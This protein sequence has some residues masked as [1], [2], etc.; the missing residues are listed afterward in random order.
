MGIFKRISDIITAN[1][2]DLTEGFENPEQ[3]LRQAIREMEESIV[4][5]T[6]ETAKALASEKV[7]RRELT[8]NRDQLQ[9][10]QQR[11]QQAVDAGDDELARKALR[12][13]R[14]HEKLVAA[15]EDQLQS[16]QQAAATLRRQLGAMKAKLAEAKRSLATLSARQRAAQFRKRM[17]SAGVEQTQEFDQNAFAKFER[18]RSRVEQAEAEAEALAELHAQ[19]AD[20]ELENETADDGM[21]QELAALKRKS[22]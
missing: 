19:G 5:A 16:S 14:E 10:W 2:N 9:C 3:M 15:L 20:V 7:L 17:A 8:G 11:A 18:F 21:E 13:K 4:T 12:R 6:H 1:L 22:H